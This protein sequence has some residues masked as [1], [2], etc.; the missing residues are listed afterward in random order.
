MQREENFSGKLLQRERM[1]YKTVAQLQK[2]LKTEIVR[3]EMKMEQ[4]E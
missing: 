2:P 4:L 1:L 3:V